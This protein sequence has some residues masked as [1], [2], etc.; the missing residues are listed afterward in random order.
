MKKKVLSLIGIFA[1][2]IL[3]IEAGRDPAGHEYSGDIKKLCK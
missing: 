1:V 3:L 2:V